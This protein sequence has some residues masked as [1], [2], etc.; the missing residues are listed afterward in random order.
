MYLIARPPAQAAKLLSLL[1][2]HDIPAQHL[3]IIDVVYD[4]AALEQ[5]AEQINQCSSV[6]FISPSAI[7][8]LGM[9]LSKLKPELN[10][11]TSGVASAKLL[12]EYLPN[13]NVIYPEHSSGVAELILESKLANL[14]TIALVGGDN[15]NAR[16]AKYLEQ[17]KVQYQ[18]INVY[19]RINSGI[20]NLELIESLICKSDIRGIVITSCQIADFL[21]E[22]GEKSPMILAVLQKIKLITIHPQIS[23]TLRKYG[24]SNIHECATAENL[25]ILAVIKDLENE[26]N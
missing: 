15:L 1:E 25:A 12:I 17:K 19:Q 14:G 26:P 16:L 3:P 18:F 22:C 8:G 21:F 6:L 9:R 7:D 4:E 2:Q 24:V 23:L 20:I 5:A 11:I 13:A 10:L